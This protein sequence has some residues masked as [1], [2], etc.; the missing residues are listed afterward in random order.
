[1]KRYAS[2]VKAHRFTSRQQNKSEVGVH[3]GTGHVRT[4]FRGNGIYSSEPTMDPKP[5]TNPYFLTPYQVLIGM[6]P[7][8]VNRGTEAYYSDVQKRNRRH[9]KCHQPTWKGRVCLQQ[10]VQ[11]SLMP[12]DVSH[13]CLHCHSDAIC[14]SIYLQGILQ[15]G[16]IC[17]PAVPQ[18]SAIYQI[19]LG[20]NWV[21]KPIT[22]KYKY[23]VKIN[24]RHHHPGPRAY[25]RK[26]RKIW[27]EIRS[28][29]LA[30]FGCFF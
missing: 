16:A 30:A 19:L 22:S 13:I 7:R 6:H 28:M 9:V 27:L 11:L 5:P 20:W 18:V 29:F 15:S 14:S 12:S 10:A 1:M 24:E 2:Q 17:C 4:L 8:S 26:F 25:P 3:S 23:F 21:G